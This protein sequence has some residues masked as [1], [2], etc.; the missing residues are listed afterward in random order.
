MPFA[1]IDI[2]ST[3]TK[4]V[5]CDD[6]ESV[7]ASHIGPTGAEHRHLALKVM[8]ETL[9]RAGLSFDV[10]D[11]MPEAVALPTSFKKFRLETSLPPKIARMTVFST[12]RSTMSSFVATGFSLSSLLFLFFAA[13]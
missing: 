8:E 1:G 11:E 2:G 13:P 4:V 9:Q 7:L 12:T 6:A 10:L 3:M 5:I